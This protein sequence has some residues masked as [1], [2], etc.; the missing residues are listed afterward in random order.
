MSD[1]RPGWAAIVIAIAGLACRPEPAT[2]LAL[3][4]A[5]EREAD[6]VPEATDAKAEVAGATLVQPAE[7]P[8]VPE[9]PPPP[10]ATPPPGTPG[11]EGEVEQLVAIDDERAIVHFAIPQ[12]DGT[13]EEFVALMRRD[14][15]IAWVQPLPDGPEDDIAILGDVVSVK[16]LDPAVERPPE[17]TLR[18]FSLATGERRY[19]IELGLGSSRGSVA[20]RERR[21][22]LRPAVTRDALAVEATDVVASTS[23]GVDWH[24]RIPRAA[25]RAGAVPMLVGGSLALRV[26]V[27]PRDAQ[28]ARWMLLDRQYSDVLGVFDARLHGCS[29]GT[30]WF[31]VTDD[32][33][34]EA[35]PR[36]LHPKPVAGPLSLPRSSGTWTIEDCTLVEGAPVVLAAQ[37]ERRALV[38][39]DV[40]GTVREHIE[41]DAAARDALATA[42]DP[43]P[44]VSHPVLALP[45]RRADDRYELHL[46]A[47]SPGRPIE[48]WRAVDAAIDWWPRPVRW[49]GGYLMGTRRLLVAIDART[50]LVEG[51]AMVPEGTWPPGPQQ[52]VGDTL[53]LPPTAPFELGTAAPRLV[54]VRTVASDDV[55][56]S[57]PFDLRVELGRG[58]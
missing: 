40:D 56:A 33:L 38:G 8:A 22:D 55:R 5:T 47:P 11:S 37:R 21:Y 1:E 29:D 35:D 46:V 15:T 7:L 51:R 4:D 14:G 58:T 30:R 57:V 20:D 24:I 31:V 13:Y 16:T 17:V 54:D 43:L 19:A 41:L 48:H 45:T 36:G 6:E 39:L 9:P 49:S 52:L 50:G 42:P 23:K 53:W 2:A 25:H 26:E 3:A 32:G 18:G 10:T 28:H 12:W 34:A 27:T 44:H